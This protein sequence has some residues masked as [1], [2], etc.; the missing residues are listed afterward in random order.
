MKVTGKMEIKGFFV[1][2]SESSEN[3]T[4]FASR[5]S[6]VEKVV[7]RSVEDG[8]MQSVGDVLVAQANFLAR[9]YVEGTA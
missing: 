9:A 7:I 8:D 1:V 2:F 4:Y 6:F 5:K 3:I